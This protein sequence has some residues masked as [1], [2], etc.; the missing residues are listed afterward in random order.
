M[1]WREQMRLP[2][3]YPHFSFLPFCY[4]FFVDF[5]SFIF[6]LG[7]TCKLL[8][9]VENVRDRGSSC[10]KFWNE[11]IIKIS[12]ALLSSIPSCKLTI[13]LLSL[14]IYFLLL[15]SSRDLSRQWLKGWA[16]FYQNQL[17]VKKL[18]WYGVLWTQFL[19]L[20]SI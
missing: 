4:F 15:F 1:V 3:L 13:L 16:W 5:F 20:K 17:N 6:I 7:L 14:G 12:F 19:S 8:V 11:L 18:G 10:E 2:L 9:T